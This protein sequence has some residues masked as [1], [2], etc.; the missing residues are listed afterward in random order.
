MDQVLAQAE[1]EDTCEP[2]DVTEEQYRRALARAQA[3]VRTAQ[4]LYQRARAAEEVATARI[5]SSARTLRIARTVL[6]RMKPLGAQ[7]QRN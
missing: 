5:L 1:R 7:F 4:E 6:S 2:I 3:Y